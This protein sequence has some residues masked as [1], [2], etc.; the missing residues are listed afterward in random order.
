MCAMGKQQEGTEGQ[1]WR[2]S[3][4]DIISA[5]YFPCDFCWGLPSLYWT[6]KFAFHSTSLSTPC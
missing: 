3:D 2:Q 1:E 5:A 4:E 6:I